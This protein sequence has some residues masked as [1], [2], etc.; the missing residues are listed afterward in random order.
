MLII[1][2]PH[3]TFIYIKIKI[4]HTLFI[5]KI[6]VKNLLK[7]YNINGY[8]L[9]FTKITILLQGKFGSISFNDEILISI[10]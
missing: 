3:S 7:K 6:N 2:F 5:K 10:N 4:K 9:F 8:Q 1:W